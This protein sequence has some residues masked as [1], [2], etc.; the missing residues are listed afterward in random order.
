[1]RQTR[2]YSAG[3][4]AADIGREFFAVE[5]VVSEVVFCCFSA[6]D[7]LVYEMVLAA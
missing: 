4:N 3:S 7:L 6:E 2:L 5:H 1:M